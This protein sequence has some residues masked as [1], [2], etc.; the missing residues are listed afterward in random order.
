MAL[1]TLKFIANSKLK[2]SSMRAD[3]VAS[4][5]TNQISATATECGLNEWG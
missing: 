4:L 5:K 1:C 3:Y 2:V